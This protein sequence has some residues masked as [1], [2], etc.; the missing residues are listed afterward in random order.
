MEANAMHPKRRAG[1]S[2]APILK[3]HGDDLFKSAKIAQRGRLEDQLRQIQDAEA[4]TVARA[5]VASGIGKTKLYEELNSGRLR[6]FMLCGR[7]LILRDDLIAW[8]RAARDAA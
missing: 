7:R 4:Y 6:S 2:H 1:A 3:D 8:L 5:L